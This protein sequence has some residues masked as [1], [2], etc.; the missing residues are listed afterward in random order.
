[1]TSQ[2]LFHVLV[3]DGPTAML[4][5]D[6]ERRI[7]LVNRGAEQLFG[8]PRESL[9]GQSIEL[10]VPDRFVDAHALH[11]DGYFSDEKPRCIS[12][13]TERQI[14]GRHRDGSDIPI[15]IGLSP[16]QSPAGQCV[17]ASII[18]ITSRRR[19]EDGY[20]AVVEAAPNAIV[21]MDAGRRITM[22]N[23][24]AVE[25]F[26][27]T[28]EALIGAPIEM[29][30]P[31]VMIGD[32]TAAA[33]SNDA[34]RDSAA[35]RKDGSEVPVEISTSQVRTDAG[36]F[37]VVSATDI[38]KR[39]HAEDELRRSN[40]ELEQFAYVASHDL[41]EPLRM[42]AS[43]TELLAQRYRGKLDEKADKYIE[44]ATDGAK[45]MQ[46]LV[47]DLLAYSRVGS[48]GKALDSVRCGP[49]VE[50]VLRAL[51]G[52]I[53]N[54][55]ATVEVGEL[56]VVMADETQLGQVMQ[57][58]IANAV[59]FRGDEPPRIR[60][61][62]TREGDAWH[63]SV[64]DNGIG[65]DP[66]YAERVFQMFQRLHERGRFEGSGIGLAIAK[67]I[68]ERHGGRIWF[69]STGTGTTF[70]FTL[71]AALRGSADPQ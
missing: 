67:R 10:L 48:G 59:K 65:I 37:T 11:L 70:H 66:Q 45:R 16:I 7:S 46:Q 43:Y 27:Y 47:M 56:P 30:F 55:G 49:L 36:A 64:A 32:P 60:V 61:L 5:V 3:E 39:K 15:E 58:L 1:M 57:N 26:G 28:R 18:D 20:R 52:S 63:F 41:Q 24:S 62:A 38:T 51:A 35:R 42:V 22:V 6:G 2:S 53:R 19:A 34:P 12:L 68:V 50:Q 23:R 29:L 40:A 17:L 54:A 13:G 69:T 9:L 14:F 31:A 71:N 8:Y 25:L 21:M 4:V 33:R 44:Y